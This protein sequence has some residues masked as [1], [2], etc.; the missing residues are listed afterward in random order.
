MIKLGATQLCGQAQHVL[1]QY[2]LHTI[3]KCI[4]SWKISIKIFL[5]IS[6]RCRKGTSH[7]LTRRWLTSVTYSCVTRH[8]HME[9][10]DGTRAPKSKD[11]PSRYGI[12]IMKIRSFC[13]HNGILYRWG[14]V[15]IVR[16]PM[17]Q[18]KGSLSRF[19][20]HYKDKTVVRS[21]VF[22]M[23]IH[24]L[25]RQYIYIMTGPCKYR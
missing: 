9:W 6:A 2:I 4:L 15:V 11:R 25:V 14:S 21:V 5:H 3:F 1:H 17:P 19:G 16:R 20:S 8:R 12:P 24:I 10:P 7:C 13:L 23:G 18:C 22:I